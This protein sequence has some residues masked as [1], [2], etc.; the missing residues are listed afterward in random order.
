MNMAGSAWGRKR[1]A[2]KEHD[3]EEYTTGPI[4]Y[5]RSAESNRRG[6]PTR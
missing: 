1:P 5:K 2:T 3:N 6:T 4:V